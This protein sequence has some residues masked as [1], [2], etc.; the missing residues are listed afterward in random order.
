MNTKSRF[1][2]PSFILVLAGAIAIAQADT[3]NRYARSEFAPVNLKPILSAAADVTLAKYPDCDEATVER[4]MV[5]VYRPDGTGEAQDE[6]FTKVLTEKGKRN[7]RTL[8]LSFMLPYTTVEVARLE[9]IK[10]SGEVV[11][12]DVAANSKEVI[13]D[14]QMSM[15]IYDPNMKILRVNIPSL[16]IGDVV[17]SITRQ[18]LQRPIIPGE[19]SEE[20]VFEGTGYIR[21]ISYD[22]Y[23]PG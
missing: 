10:P 8:A 3:T 17:H 2:I 19:F 7:N 6:G 5:R 4:K 12:V 11:P 15:N 13:D 1:L 18:N 16:E 14:S 20:S 22:V 9:V 23:A 21:H